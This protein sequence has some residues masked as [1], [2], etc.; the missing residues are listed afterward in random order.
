MYDSYKMLVLGE[1]N[2]F[3]IK[4]LEYSTMRETAGNPMNYAR[5][6]GFNRS[7]GLLEN[8][9][10]S[11]AWISISCFAMLAL[12]TKKETLI[13]FLVIIIYSIILLISLNFTSIIAFSFVIIFVELKGFLLFRAVI[14]KSSLKA[15]LVGLIVFVLAYNFN[16]QNQGEMVIAIR[17][18]IILHSELATGNIEY[19]DATFFNKFI[20]SFLSFPKNMLSFPPGILIGD[21]FSSWGSGKGGDFGHAETLHQLGLPFYIAVIIGLFKLIK[22]SLCKIQILNLKIHEDGSYLYFAVCVLL[23]ILITTLH[24]STWSAKSVLPIFFISIAI[25]SR[26]FTSQTN[27][28][29]NK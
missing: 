14:A 11:A 4:I 25:I 15:L 6:S 20:I 27:Q 1:V 12:L 26:D 21:G 10:I 22:L 5:I 28:Y 9:A 13:R 7:H 18:S 19:Q 8:H 24:Y 3:S 2:D 16:I 17:E 23:Y 29:R